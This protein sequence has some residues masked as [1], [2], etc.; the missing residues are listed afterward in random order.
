MLKLSV[1]IIHLLPFS[2]AD[3]HRVAAPGPPATRDI[4]SQDRIRENVG[5]VFVPS[6]LVFFGCSSHCQFWFG[7]LDQVGAT[8]D[9]VFLPLQL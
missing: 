7:F 2:V 6:A 9:G 8:F 3:M 1:N 4:P 5:E